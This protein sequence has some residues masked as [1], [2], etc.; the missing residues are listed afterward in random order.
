[1]RQ[2][3]RVSRGSRFGLVALVIAGVGLV[4]AAGTAG[5][6]AKPPTTTK[7]TGSI[8]VSGA[9]SLTEAFTKMGTDFQKANPGTTI[10]FN[11]G[12]S[13]TLAQQIQGGAPADV[14]ASADGANMQKLVTGGQVTAEPTVLASNL[15]TIVVKPGNPKHVKTLADLAKLDVVSLCGETV[16]CG[17]YTDQILTGAGVTIDPSKVTRGADVKA[18]LA[19]V[20]TGDADA[21]I[22]YVTDAKSAGTSAVSIPIPTWQN[23]YAIYPIAPIAAST[24]QD[25]DNAWIT[26]TISPAGQKTL[27]SFGFLP[28]PPS[29]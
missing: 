20:T 3:Q 8:T 21:A 16:P 2:E 23:A 9:A 11:F 28:P 5:A 10:T 7:V 27:K 6:K 19:A 4:G 12:S 26:Y 15:L 24:N 22:V 13:G 25:L 29:E 17:K 1:M 18:T 14:F